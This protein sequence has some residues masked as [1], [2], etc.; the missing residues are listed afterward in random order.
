MTYQRPP[1]HIRDDDL[2]KVEYVG[3]KLRITIGDQALMQAAENIPCHEFKVN[4]DGDFLKSFL[5]ALHVEQEDGT[6]L[7]HRM[8]DDAAIWC[9]EQGMEGLGYDE[10]GHNAIGCPGCIDHCPQKATRESCDCP[11][12]DGVTTKCRLGNY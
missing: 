2:L 10:D 4:H 8:L 1:R 11:N 3:N 7:V 6:T 5:H 9:L 12:V